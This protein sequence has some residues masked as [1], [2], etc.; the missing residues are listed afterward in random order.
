MRREKKK[1]ACFDLLLSAVFFILLFRQRLVMFSHHQ[2][3]MNL[4]ELVHVYL[5][6]SAD[7]MFDKTEE[8]KKPTYTRR[9]I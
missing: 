8:E 6:D 2:Y 5:L 1:L 7:V 3:Y 4:I 9:E